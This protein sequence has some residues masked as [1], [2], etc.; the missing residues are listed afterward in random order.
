[1]VAAVPS[2]SAAQEVPGVGTPTSGL[3]GEVFSSAD[4]LPIP[5]V[6]PFVDGRTLEARALPGMPVAAA[7]RLMSLPV[8]MESGLDGRPGGGELIFAAAATPWPTRR[9]PT[10]GQDQEVWGLDVP[11]VVEIDGT[12]LLPA[13]ESGTATLEIYVYALAL[14]EERRGEVLAHRAEA[15]DL[16]ATVLE[17]AMASGGLKVHGRL[18]LDLGPHQLRFLLRLPATGAEGWRVVEVVGMDRRSDHPDPWVGWLV[19]EPPGRWWTVR[20]SDWAPGGEPYPMV[21]GG[22]ALVPAADPVVWAEH[23]VELAVLGAA[24]APGSWDVSWRLRSDR[25]R[26]TVVDLGA[27]GVE[28]DERLVHRLEGRL[29]R[30]PPGRYHAALELRAADSGSSLVSARSPLWI[31]RGTRPERGLL[32]VDL[33]HLLAP[34]PDDVPEVSGARPTGRR[35]RRG[36]GA[37]DDSAYRALLTE[38]GGAAEGD[39]PKADQL[40]RLEAFRRLESEA[41]V[42]RGEPLAG[43]MAMEESVAVALA[44]ENPEALLPLLVLH[45]EA[46]RV[47]LRRQ[48]RRLISHSRIRVSA[49]A[50]RYG[51]QGSDPSLAADALVTLAA[52]LQEAGLHAL[53]AGFYHDALRIDPGHRAARL[54]L[55]V[56]LER[57]GDLGQARA[58]LDQLLVAHPDDPEGLLRRAVIHGRGGRGE[59]AEEGLEALRRLEKA[60]PWIAVACRI[61]LARLWLDT[62]EEARAR[63]VLEEAVASH[64]TY[65]GPRLLLAQLE[66]R[67]GHTA[68]ARRW[69]APWIGESWEARAAAPD[70]VEPI[71]RRYDDRPRGALTGAEQRLRSASRARRAALAEALGS[72]GGS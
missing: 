40:R 49:L 4:R 9:S 43:L 39:E 63:P 42:G 51:A 27:L 60:P 16:S 12:T 69:L 72:G 2:W 61:E 33:R 52:D 21:E 20:G 67:L 47:Y 34:K 1:M 15:V 57:I 56:I 8:A 13:L 19:P 38:L 10:S 5:G 66:N 31:L 22:R 3:G 24:L 55:V 25:G 68:A 37:M 6:D 54:A 64:P 71:G 30:L 53:A 32:W 46:Y 36:K 70:A 35:G 45:L 29:P 59:A 14:E 26:E 65:P 62:G 41:L 17:E 18:S 48:A 44:G 58:H 11:W 28:G 50:E 7:R 23:A